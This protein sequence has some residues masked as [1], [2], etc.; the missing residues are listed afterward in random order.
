[1]L[2]RVQESDN[3]A[4]FNIDDYLLKDK[5]VLLSRFDSRKPCEK[6][7]IVLDASNFSIFNT[8]LGGA[9]A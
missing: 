5:I 4:I 3:D 8:L 1:M 9:S 6:T 2:N 7:A